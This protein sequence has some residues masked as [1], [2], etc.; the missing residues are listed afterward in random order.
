[1]AVS[2]GQRLRALRQARGL[3]VRDVAATAAITSTCLARIEHDRVAPDEALICRLAQAVDPASTDELLMLAG[4]LPPDVRSILQQHPAE[5]AQLLRD[6]FG[7]RRAVVANGCTRAAF[8]PDELVAA[9]VRWAVRDAGDSVLDPACGDGV[10][11]AAAAARLGELGVDPAALARQVHGYDTDPESAARAVRRLGQ[12]T[13]DAAHIVHAEDFL[14]VE[15]RARLPFHRSG[16]ATV[17]AVIGTIDR[18]GPGATSAR[19]HARRVAAEAGV[20]LP[21][22]A[23]EWVALIAH[24]ASFV[25]PE[26]RLGLLVPAVFLTAHYAA[27]ARRYLAQLFPQLTVITFEPSLRGMVEMAVVLGAAGDAHDVRTLRVSSPAAVA[28]ALLDVERAPHVAEARAL[29]WSRAS[30][31]TRSRLA[32][33]SLQRAG[34]LRRLG[35]LVAIDAGTVTG[36]NHFFVLSAAAAENVAPEFVQPMLASP[37]DV[38]G[39]I[40]APK[41][42]QAIAARGRA[43]Y[44]LVV[45]PDAS[46]DRATRGYL[47]EG[48]RLGISARATCRRRPAW[49]ALPKPGRPPAFLP[50][51]CRH[52]PRML[53]NEADVTHTNAL[54]SVRPHPGV[55]IA[56]VATSLLSTPA[57]LGC[58]LLGRR[59]GSGLKLEPTEM[60]NLLVPDPTQRSVLLDGSVLRAADALWRAGREDEAIAEVD[61]VLLGDALTVDGAVV[62][63][64]RACY[65][66]ERA[67]RVRH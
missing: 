32:L 66:A 8:V 6:H 10:W 30:L 41:D 65:E 16:P 5:S 2:L 64:L 48:E 36:A 33:R 35:D 24:A 34:V 12:L 25:H 21:Q 19:D 1:M 15:P 63:E 29:R 23:P 45:P 39:L 40:V 28:S 53:L 9:L 57:L 67:R 37:N 46:L 43:C 51:L 27:D 50:Y 11:L 56:A 61:R 55:N 52:R 4:Y 62:A 60:E 54:H 3:R 42:W 20:T 14:R 13:S 49:Y 7:R 38:P 59:F 22:S 47:R 17:A 18:R 58:E 26:G 31:P 44:L